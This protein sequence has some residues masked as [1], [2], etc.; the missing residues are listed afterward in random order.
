[1]FGILKIVVGITAVGAS[2]YGGDK[3]IKKAKE[4][5][6]ENLLAHENRVAVKKALAENARIL[7]QNVDT[8]NM[9]ISEVPVD[10]RGSDEYHNLCGQLLQNDHQLRNTVAAFKS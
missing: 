9:M 2:I 10:Q 6:K 8:L 5:K 1:M 4:N 7:R 3:L